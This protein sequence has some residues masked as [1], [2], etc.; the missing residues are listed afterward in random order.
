MTVSHLAQ[1][2]VHR[3][4]HGEKKK[5]SLA[6]VIAMRPRLILLDEPSAGLDPL[7]ARE[8]IHLIQHLNNHHAYS[9]VTVTHDLNLV[10]LIARRMVLMDHGRTLA[11]GPTERIL[12][13]TELLKKA[14]LVPPV[15]TQLFDQLSREDSITGGAP[16]TVAQAAA[17]LRRMTHG[18]AK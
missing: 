14:R 12:N 18:E 6:G 8:L 16:L 3:L 1:R 11:Q 13:D 7:G 5:V 17:R 2:P 10:P 9:F 4:S 15:L